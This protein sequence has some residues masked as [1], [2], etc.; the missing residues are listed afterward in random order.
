MLL[1]FVCAPSRDALRFRLIPGAALPQYA[2]LRRTG[3]SPPGHAPLASAGATK[4]HAFED[5]VIPA[6]LARLPH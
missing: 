2:S 6:P 4:A 5:A 1:S 3:H